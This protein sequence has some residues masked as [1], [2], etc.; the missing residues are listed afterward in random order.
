LHNFV[1]KIKK[2]NSN[3]YKWLDIHLGDV[4]IENL[5]ETFKKCKKDLFDEI[6]A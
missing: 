4:F 3:L 2:S 5:K 6:S 1:K